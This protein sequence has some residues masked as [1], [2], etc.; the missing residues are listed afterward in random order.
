MES[1]RN[2]LKRNRIDI[3]FLDNLDNGFVAIAFPVID[4]G[5]YL[6]SVDGGVDVGI[7][8]AYDIY[9]MLVLGE[10]SGYIVCIVTYAIH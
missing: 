3:V 7:V 8:S 2:I 10:L 1:V 4:Y 6:Y 9:F 5:K